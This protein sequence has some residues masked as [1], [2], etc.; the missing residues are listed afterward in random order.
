MDSPPDLHGDLY[1]HK[2]S[3]KENSK[4]EAKTYSEGKGGGQVTRGGRALHCLGIGYF[5][6]HSELIGVMNVQ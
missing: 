3:Q 5:L 1:W 4:H 6:Q 2:D